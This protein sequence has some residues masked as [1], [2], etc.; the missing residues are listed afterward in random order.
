M[1]NNSKVIKATYEAPYIKFLV[2][3]YLLSPEENNNLKR[4]T[5]GNWWVYWDE[6]HYINK[7][8]K[9]VMAPQIYANADDEEIYRYAYDYAEQATTEYYDE[10]EFDDKIEEHIEEYGSW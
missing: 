5:V 4:D 10:D 7:E 2:P 9:E 3:D 8:G 1:S 6:L